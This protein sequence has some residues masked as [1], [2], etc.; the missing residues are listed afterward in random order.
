MDKQKR[1]GWLIG[2][3]VFLI[4][5][6]YATGVFDQAPSTVDVPKIEFDES[7]ID[8]ILIEGD[9]A[10]L[11][12][13][14]KQSNGFWQMTRPV[15]WLADSVAISSFIRILSDLTLETVVSRNA[16]RY[17]RYG[18]DSTGFSI[19]V[20][21]GNDEKRFVVSGDG[22]DFSTVYLRLQ[23]D[24][25]VFVAS[26]RLSPPSNANLWRDKRIASI[27]A[28]SILKI[29]VRT[30]ETSYSVD[31]NESGWTL[32][33]DGEIVQA[34]SAAVVRWIR[35][36]ASFRSDD[37]LSIET[38][39]EGST[40]ILTFQLQ[41]G[42]AVNFHILERENDLVLRYDREPRAVYKI[43]KSRQAAL[44]PDQTTLIS[45]E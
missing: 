30:P 32:E 19:T 14:V 9:E 10:E 40:N 34:D 5:V 29:G 28:I 37:F 12:M 41:S 7:V 36:F 4:I 27:P 2:L 38:E 13:E 16:E 25:R 33:S 20:G 24:D 21:F 6:A 17:G 35:N 26:P 15:A 39:M 45:S 1:I 42:E 3:L 22:P 11:A 43:F 44:L 31:R 8:R 18:V 23:D